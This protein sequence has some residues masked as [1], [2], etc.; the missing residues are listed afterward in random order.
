MRDHRV[1]RFDLLKQKMA[2]P[3]T[4]DD[5]QELISGTLKAGDRVWFVGGVE[6]RPPE[7][8]A[9]YL[10]PA[11]YSYFGWQ[12]DAYA[13]LWSQQIGVFL[14]HHASGGELLRVGTGGRVNELEKVDLLVI[15]G[16]HE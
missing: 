15:E 4:I 2:S 9:P 8:G 1:H 16:W 3:N 11:P 10:P 6:F 14:R 5:L 12:M 7:E 13:E